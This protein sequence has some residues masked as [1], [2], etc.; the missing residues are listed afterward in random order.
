MRPK[1]IPDITESETEMLKGLLAES[2]SLYK[3]TPDLF[4]PL[5]EAGRVKEYGRHEVIMQPGVRLRDVHIVIDG[6]VGA[7]YLSGN[8]VI[9]HALATPGTLLLHGGSFFQVRPSFMQWEALVKTRTLCV[10]DAFV[11]EY[12]HKSHEFAIWMY[13]VAENNIL[14][15]EEKTYILAD[16]AEQRYRKLAKNLPRRVF[17]E[18]S[19][20]VMASYLG[21]TEQS[22]S[23]IKRT[24]LRDSSDPDDP[25]GDYIFK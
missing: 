2:E 20:R 13:G 9:M 15:S 22:L 17:R 6:L 11:R 7:T 3:T 25:A 10:P 5:F 18:L 8:K 24:V 16:C 23:R 12:L 21:I 1:R 14:H 19:S 4:D